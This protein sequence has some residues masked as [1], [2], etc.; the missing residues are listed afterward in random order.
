MNVKRIPN[1]QKIFNVLFLS[2]S[3]TTKNPI[4][5]AIWFL[6]RMNIA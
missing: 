2:F 6:L 5:S 3:F 4:Y 1:P